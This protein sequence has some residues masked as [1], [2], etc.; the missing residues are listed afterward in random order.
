MTIQLTEAELGLIKE[1]LH[2]ALAGAKFYLFGSRA[3]GTAKPCSDADVVVV[4]DEIIPL[5]ILSDLNE[6]FSESALAFKIDLV[7]WQRISPEFRN[8]IKSEWV[9]I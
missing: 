7:D 1:T 9:E 6:R 4:S 3:R 5:A 8:K 2:S